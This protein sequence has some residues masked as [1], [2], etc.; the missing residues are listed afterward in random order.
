[1][2]MR[3]VLSLSLAAALAACSGGGGRTIPPLGS[4][5][6]ATTGAPAAVPVLKLV[7]V[8]DSLTAGVQSNGLMGSDVAPLPRVAGWGSDRP[9]HA[10]PRLLGAVVVA[11]QRRGSQ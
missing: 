5:T 3:A 2:S 4:A 8:G 6:S 11:S 7:G 1:M 9:G 10:D